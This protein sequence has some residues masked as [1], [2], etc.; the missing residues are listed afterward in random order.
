MPCLVRAALPHGVPHPNPNPFPTASAPRG[1]AP[2]PPALFAQG[3]KVSAGA[4][5]APR[6]CLATVPRDQAA[7]QEVLSPPAWPPRSYPSGIVPPSFPLG[8]VPL[9][10]AGKMAFWHPRRWA[11]TYP[12][13]TGLGGAVRGV[14][15][16]KSHPT[17]QCLGALYGVGGLGSSDHSRLGARAGAF[18]LAPTLYSLCHLHLGRKRPPPHQLG[19]PSGCSPLPHPKRIG[20]PGLGAGRRGSVPPHHAVP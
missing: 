15:G 7:L 20:V 5:A 4:G 6:S 13:G 19:V 17:P 3:A 10:G 16:D 14:P 8:T 1:S 11:H 18:L 9:S 12:R 2:S